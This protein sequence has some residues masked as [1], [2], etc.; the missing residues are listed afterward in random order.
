MLE[1]YRSLELGDEER[2][3]MLIGPARA[4]LARLD[5]MTLSWQRSVSRSVLG[6]VFC[7]CA[8]L[9]MGALLPFGSG[10]NRLVIGAAAAVFAI[11]AGCFIYRMAVLRFDL[12]PLNAFTQELRHGLHLAEQASLDD[13]AEELDP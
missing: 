13:V 8:A 10:D 5:V 2:L 4:M 7:F 6:A 1:S 12:A 11:A 3:A 9:G